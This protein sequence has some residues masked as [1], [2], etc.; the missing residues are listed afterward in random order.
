MFPASTVR[1]ACSFPCP[2]KVRLRPGQEKNTQAHGYLAIFLFFYCDGQDPW[3]LW[4]LLS[5]FLVIGLALE[6]YS[7]AKPMTG[8]MKDSL[9]CNNWPLQQS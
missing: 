4:A 1:R 5:F 7:E 3:R 9:T 2:G 6:F 8:K